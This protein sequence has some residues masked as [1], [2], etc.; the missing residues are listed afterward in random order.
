PPD[1]PVEVRMRSDDYGNRRTSFASRAQSY[2]PAQIPL[3]VR[4]LDVETADTL[5]FAVAVGD[6]TTHVPARAVHRG[7]DSVDTEAGTFAAD[8]IAVTYDA[9]VPSPIGET[10][11]TTEIYW[12]GTGPGRRLLRVAAGSGRYQMTLVEHL[13]TAY[14]NEN[15]WPRLSRIESRP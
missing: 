4:G 14:W 11:A 12:V 2:P 5:A 13:R 10:S 6:S 1:G 3:L 8:R 7:R 15:L 9:P